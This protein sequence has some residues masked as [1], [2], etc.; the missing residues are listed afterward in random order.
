[1][2][3]SWPSVGLVEYTAGEETGR[4]DPEHHRRVARDVVVEDRVRRERL[5]RSPR[6]SRACCA[7]I[8]TANSS[9]G[10]DDTCGSCANPVLL[11][12][13]RRAFEL[14]A[15]SE[16]LAPLLRAV[17]ARVVRDRRTTVR[18]LGTFVCHPGPPRRDRL[19]PPPPSRSISTIWSAFTVDERDVA[20]TR[21]PADRR[22]VPATDLVVLGLAC[23]S[24]TDVPEY[25]GV[26]PRTGEPVIVPGRGLLG[27]TLQAS[28]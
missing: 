24:I 10:L 16:A 12:T 21:A 9:P 13:Y 26:N 4:F 25:R 5:R 2:W 11:A 3:D 15:E 27:V 20:A 28:E 18:G 8:A 19:Y 7:I 17:I 6:G 1:M 14:A 22:L 23:F